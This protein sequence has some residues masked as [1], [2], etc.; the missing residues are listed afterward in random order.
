MVH[1][2]LILPAAQDPHEEQPI[3]PAGPTPFATA[4][5]ASALANE[6]TVPVASPPRH[7]DSASNNTPPVHS[8][9]HGSGGDVSHDAISADG[10]S[11]L[12]GIQPALHPAPDATVQAPA[13]SQ[14]TT[15]VGATADA[16]RLLVALNKFDFN[17]LCKLYSVTRMNQYFS[18]RMCGDSHSLPLLAICLTA[19]LVSNRQGPCAFFQ[20]KG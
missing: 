6:P 7:A 12:S 20:D 10:V 3:A 16:S 4:P 5:V 13:V 17:P 14:D 1:V 19:R 18:I 2:P 8:P 9:V 15:Q 11:L